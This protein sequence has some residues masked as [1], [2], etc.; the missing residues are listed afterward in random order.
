MF[1]KL[2]IVDIHDFYHQNRNARKKMEKMHNPTRLP[3][4]EMRKAVPRQIKWF[5]QH[6][7][8]TK[9]KGQEP[10][11]WHRV[12]SS[13]RVQLESSRCRPSP[14]EA[15]LPNLHSHHAHIHAPPFYPDPKYPH[16]KLLPRLPSVSAQKPGSSGN[17]RE[18]Q[19]TFI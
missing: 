16:F 10:K 4:V 7:T 14:G 2:S 5:T 3:I 19:R 17:P 15:P 12:C 11:G 13:P 9:W 6:H 18:G 1:S 8:D